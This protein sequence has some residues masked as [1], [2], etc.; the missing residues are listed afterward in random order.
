ME[1]EAAK[2]LLGAICG[3][4]LSCRLAG[5]MHGIMCGRLLDSGKLNLSLSR[6]DWV[7][8]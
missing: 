3:V 4:K 2:V 6:A 5:V 8:D 7:A 1:K